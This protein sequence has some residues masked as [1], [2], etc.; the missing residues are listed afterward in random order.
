[1]I[2]YLMPGTERPVPTTQ[3]ITIA[4]DP[5]LQFGDTLR[6]HDRDGFGE[7][8]DVQIQGIR[9]S[10]SVDNGLTDTL[11][12]EMIAPPGGIWDSAQYGIWEST[13]VWGD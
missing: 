3:A 2:S 11:S 6:I 10:Y 5:R 7:R 9:R 4:G 13:F 8:V 1:M 12:V